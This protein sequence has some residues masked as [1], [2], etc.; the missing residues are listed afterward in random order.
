MENK[1]N[2][3]SIGGKFRDKNRVGIVTMYYKSCNYGGLLQAYALC[4]FLNENGYDAKQI[5]Y[6]F[7]G[8]E[9]NLLQTKHNDVR[10]YLR[11]IRR[12]IKKRL[13][14]ADNRKHGVSNLESARRETCKAFRDGIPHTFQVYNDS[15]I[16]ETQD[17]F[18]CFIT[19]SDQVWNPI[20]Y[21]PVFFLKF[22]SDKRKKKISFAASTSNNN[23]TDDVKSIY[24]DNLKDFDLISVREKSDATVLQEI[25]DLPVHWVLDPVFLLDKEQWMMQCSNPFDANYRP[26]LFCYFLGDDLREREMAAQYGKKHGLTL[27][28]IPYLQ[29]NYRECDEFFGDIQLYDVDPTGFLGLIQGADCVF[30]DSFHAT[31]FSIIFNKQFVV[32]GRSDHPEMLERIRSITMLFNCENRLLADYIQDVECIEKLMIDGRDIVYQ[33]SEFNILLIES[34]KVLD[35]M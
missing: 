32:F 8:K 14:T 30:T 26:Y 19:G 11:I 2:I 15:D 13:I 7:Y 31:A 10:K 23:L 4:H 12:I 9:R 27:V 3:K 25:M 1:D 33:S 22:V 6:D 16:A 35:L 24:H 28:T 17:L 34:M 20:G 29:M 18:D 21:R 5:C